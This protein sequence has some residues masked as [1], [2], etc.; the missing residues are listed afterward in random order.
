M[1]I[2]CTI[3]CIFKKYGS[4]YSTMSNYRHSIFKFPYFQFVSKRKV[5][6]FESWHMVWLPKL[7]LN[8][9]YMTLFWNKTIAKDKTSFTLHKISSP[10]CSFTAS[11]LDVMIITKISLY[12]VCT[13]PKAST[14]LRQ[15]FLIDYRLCL[16]KVC[17]KYK[18]KK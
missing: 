9:K 11:L 5:L 8:N 15:I 3:H 17:F 14:S 13:T 16:I 10:P 1:C 7:S 12:V 2:F 6:P 18:N 4:R